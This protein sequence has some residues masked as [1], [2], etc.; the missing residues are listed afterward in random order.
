[1]SDR[2]TFRARR[3]T[4]KANVW[5]PSYTAGCKAGFTETIENQDSPLGIGSC[6]RAPLHAEASDLVQLKM[7]TPG[8]PHCICMC[9][10]EVQVEMLVLHVGL[11]Y[12][13]SN[14]SS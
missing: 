14:A 4:E 2:T 13:P 9:I 11:A 10:C 12:W 8:N 5:Q 3:S 6:E 1:M 7:K